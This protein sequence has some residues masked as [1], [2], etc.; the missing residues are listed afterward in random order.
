MTRD[1]NLDRIT[2]ALRAAGTLDRDQIAR[3]FSA[4][5]WARIGAVTFAELEADAR[6]I[7]DGTHVTVDPE[8]AWPDEDPDEAGSPDNC[9]VARTVRLSDVV[10]ERI[11]WLWPGRIPA[12][13]LA[14]LDGDPSL[15]KSTLCLEFARPITTGT[16][17]PDGAPCEP[18]SVLL[19]SAEDG[20]ADTV[21]PRLDAAGADPDRVVA[22]TEVLVTIGGETTSRPVTLADVDLIADSILTAQARLAIV[23]V[24]MAYMPDNRNSHN[25]Q[26]VRA[27]LSRLATIAEATGCTILLIRHLNKQMGGTALYRG[28]GSIGIVGAARAAYLVA[29]DPDDDTGEARI[30]APTKTNLSTT[31]DSLRYRL[32]SAPGSDV[33][34]VEWLGVSAHRAD[35][36]LAHAGGD[37]EDRAERSAAEDWLTAYL[38]DRNRGGTASAVE[39]KRAAAAAGF[40]DKALRSARERVCIKP[41]KDGMAGGWTWSL[42][43]TVPED[44]SKVPKMP[45]RNERASSAPSR[46]PSA[47]QLVPTEPDTAD[48]DPVA[49]AD[50]S[51]VQLRIRAKD[52]AIAAGAMTEHDTIP[53]AYLR[54]FGVIA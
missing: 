48:S 37:D 34:R 17:W 19:M 33:A 20:L 11:S 49:P 18:G 45:T 21:R 14:V 42:K 51:P 28:G 52:A 8:A 5:T 43:G 23:D 32:V 15:G 29:K 24:L 35:D 2:Y 36:L 54:E 38:S 31:P 27:V 50:E 22:L 47:L 30:F 4:V 46:A 3:M 26:A 41:V 13:K 1:E 12:G 7:V 16:P 53:A 10:P 40:A 25:D 39:V 6:F 44:A 9:T